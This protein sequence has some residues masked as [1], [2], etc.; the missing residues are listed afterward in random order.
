MNR[1]EGGWASFG[2][3]HQRLDAI[4]RRFSIRF[5][6]LDRDEHGNIWRWEAI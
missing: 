5:T 1:Q 2:V 3:P 6:G 4:R